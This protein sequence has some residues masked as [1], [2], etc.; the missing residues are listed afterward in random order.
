MERFSGVVRRV[1][2]RRRAVML[3]VG[4]RDEVGGGWELHQTVGKRE[5]EV[6]VEDGRC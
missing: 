2:L 4:G 5:G 6:R 3:L 1:I